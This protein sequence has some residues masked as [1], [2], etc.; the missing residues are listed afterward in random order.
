MNTSYVEQI[1]QEIEQMPP[2]YLPALFTIIHSFRASI[3]LNTAEDSFKQGF[4][5]FL[6]LSESFCCSVSRLKLVAED[7]AFA[8]VCKQAKEE[9]EFISNEEA[10]AFIQNLKQ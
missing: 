3:C 10:H 1:N 5:D 4:T 2:E 9:N 8:L 7:L 6:A